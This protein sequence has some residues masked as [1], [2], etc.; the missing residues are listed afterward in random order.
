MN[1]LRLSLL[2]VVSLASAT[3]SAATLNVV[4]GQLLGAQGVEID[5]AIFDVAFLDGTCIS[6][7]SGCDQNADFAIVDFSQA[8]VAAQALLDQVFLDVPGNGEFDSFS[9]LTNGCSDSFICTAYI[10]FGTGGAFFV[11]ASATNVAS[12]VEDLTG[13]P[14][15]VD[16]DPVG[17]FLATVST[18]GDQATTFAVFTLVTP[19][20]V[21]LPASL[22]LLAA[23]L[24]CI[25][26][27]KG[28][29][30]N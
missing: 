19:A 14:D 22:P 15:S 26:W 11:A 12:I 16:P 23:A 17:P 27:R 1:N 24:A 28:R 20:P 7:F 4:N 2:L 18:S 30:V 21:P 5:G 9:A 8:K 10:P 13:T 25:R 6:L 29:R 3:A